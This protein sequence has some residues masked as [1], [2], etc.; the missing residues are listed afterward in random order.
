[1][2]DVYGVIKKSLSYGEF[3]QAYKCLEQFIPILAMFE[4]D[5]PLFRETV[6]GTFHEEEECALWSYLRSQVRSGRES[7]L[8]QE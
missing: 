3:V 4:A 6:L 2:V 8:Y 7:F 5:Y 1:M